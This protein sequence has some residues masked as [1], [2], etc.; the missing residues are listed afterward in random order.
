MKD[1]DVRMSAPVEAD[2]RGTAAADVGWVSIHHIGMTDD[3]IEGRTKS[4]LNLKEKRF[5]K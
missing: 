5:F 1:S 3:P 4:M 2:I